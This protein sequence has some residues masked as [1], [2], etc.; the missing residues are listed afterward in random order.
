MSNT[1]TAEIITICD[2]DNYGNRLQNYAVQELLERMGCSVST[3]WYQLPRYR[4]IKL[5]KY[6]VHKGLG[7][8]VGNGYSWK[9]G[10]MRYEAFVRFNQF[11]VHTDNVKRLSDLRDA[12]YYV[13]G[14]DQVWN[15]RWYNENR[16]KKDLFLLTFSEP[17]KKV[18]FAPSFG[19]EDILDEWKDWFAECLEDFPYISVRENAGIDIVRKLTGKQAN[20]LIDPTLMLNKEDWLKIACPVPNIQLKKPYVLTYFLGDSPQEAE[21]M[22]DK[23]IREDGYDVRK[24]MDKSDEDLFCAGPSEWLWLISNAGLILTDSYHACI[25]SFLFEKPFLVYNRIST[26]MGNM[27]SRLNTLLAFLDLERKYIDSGL[28]NDVFEHD[29]SIG[30]SRLQGER[31]HTIEFL[32]KSMGLGMD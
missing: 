5:L 11:Y 28:E 23:L 32:R 31:V 22:I 15:P 1:L 27:N 13:V 8:R 3:A 24:L 21:T 18:C 12:D 19:E 10:R 4:G 30:V 26:G 17:A 2:M 7:F 6:Y 9:L 20:I 14:S 16:L 29:Y 25:F